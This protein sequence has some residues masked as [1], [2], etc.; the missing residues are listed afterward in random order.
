ML[1]LVCRDTRICVWAL[2]ITASITLIYTKMLKLNKLALMGS[3][4]GEEFCC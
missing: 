2:F 1:I 3:V 4:Y